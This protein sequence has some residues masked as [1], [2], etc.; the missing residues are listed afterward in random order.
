MIAAIHARIAER[1]GS[2]WHP[3]WPASAWS[4]VSA[5][6]SAGWRLATLAAGPI[7]AYLALRQPVAGG[8]AVYVLLAVPL[9]LL[10]PDLLALAL[11][12]VSMAMVAY[13]YG[14]LVL[15]ATVAVLA[16]GVLPV[17]AI[18]LPAARERARVRWPVPVVGVLIALVSASAVAHVG[19]WSLEV[20]LDFIDL[21]AGLVLLAAV[22]VVP[23][24]PGAVA[25]TLVVSGVLAAGY[26]LLSGSLDG[27]RLVGLGLN[28]NYLGALLAFPVAAGV[29][30]ARHSGRIG[31][32][33]ASGVCLIGVVQTHSRAALW[34]TAAG[35]GVAGLAARP[36][37][38]QVLGAVSLALSCVLVSTVDTPVRALLYGARTASELSANSAVRAEAARVAFD[39]AVQ[40]PVRGIGY[41]LFPSFALSDPR[42]GI[43][44][45][46]HN[47]YLRLAAEAGTATFLLFLL[48]LIAGLVSRTGRASVALRAAVAAGA[49][50]LL[51]A[52]T[53]SNPIVSGGFWVCLGCLLAGQNAATDQPDQEN[54]VR[55]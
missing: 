9:A 29:G 27:G 3:S 1:P 38:Q 45:N 16:V 35:V 37:R 4:A 22:T 52:N 10:R 33:G 26:V 13:R 11:I 17:R 8:L 30:L 43:F 51:F 39:V 18:A 48:L 44:I 24:R 54:R 40:H 25:R 41:G 15:L 53:L 12:P 46:T 49:V 5:G 42:L 55:V 31:W 20:T 36:L 21:I 2:G 23:P 34:A 19:P 28:T 47:D 7:A 32:L 14:G 50:T 6:G